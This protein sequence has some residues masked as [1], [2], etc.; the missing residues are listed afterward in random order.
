MVPSSVP[1]AQAP[2]GTK[3]PVQQPEPWG[4]QM[5]AHHCPLSGSVSDKTDLPSGSV[6]V[7]QVAQSSLPLLASEKSESLFLKCDITLHTQFREF[8]S[9][10]VDFFICLPVNAVCCL[11]FNSVVLVAAINVHLFL[12]LCTT[13]L[14]P[15]TEVDS[16]YASRYLATLAFQP[17]F[18]PVLCPDKDSLLL[19]SSLKF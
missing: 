11:N 8:M 15:R 5:T 1:P 4:P 10:Y 9:L 2:S 19:E 13:I 12:T 14:T 17:S 6:T 3:I 18:T 16:L 7:N